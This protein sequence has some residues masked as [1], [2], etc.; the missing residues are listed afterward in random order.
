MARGRFNS[1]ALIQF[2]VKTPW[3]LQTTGADDVIPAGSDFSLPLSGDPSIDGPSSIVGL[4]LDPEVVFTDG[5]R[6][7]LFILNELAIP[8]T[9]ELVTLHMKPSAR[10]MFPIVTWFAEDVMSLVLVKRK[11]DV[12]TG[13]ASIVGGSRGT[14]DARLS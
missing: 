5:H 12:N 11:T 13:L 9:V 3:G 7:I 10:K 6:M 14:T 8:S 1:D 2:D 4:L